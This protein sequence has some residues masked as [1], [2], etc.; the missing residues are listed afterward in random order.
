V[1]GDGGRGFEGSPPAWNDDLL[2]TEISIL[3]ASRL[4]IS[5]QAN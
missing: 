3:D 2:K 4:N 1:R 5:A